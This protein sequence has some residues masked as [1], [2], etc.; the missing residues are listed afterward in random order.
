MR[1]TAGAASNGEPPSSV[2]SLAAAA[3]TW[4]MESCVAA[5]KQSFP[6]ASRS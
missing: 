2:G 1:T 4:L 5:S 6:P 3:E